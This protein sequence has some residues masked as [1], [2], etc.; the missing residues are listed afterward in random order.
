[1]DCSYA[2]DLYHALHSS[3][4]CACTRPHP[5]NLRLHRLTYDNNGHARQNIEHDGGQFELLLALGDD[6]I[7]DTSR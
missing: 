3:F 6:D 4:Q 5:A 7:D 1:M 2:V